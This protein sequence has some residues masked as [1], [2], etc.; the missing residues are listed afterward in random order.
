MK[1]EGQAGAEQ[2]SE[3][4]KMS[5]GRT[6]T[7][8]K[9]HSQFVLLNFCSTEYLLMNVILYII[10]SLTKILAKQKEEKGKHFI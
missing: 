2:G 10:Y 4:G 7:V 9:F 6:R 3:R 5:G 1:S 8:K